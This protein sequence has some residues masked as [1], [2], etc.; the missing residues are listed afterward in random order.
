MSSKTTPKKLTMQE[1]D[2]SKFER[3]QAQL[4][5]LYTEI[6]VLAKGKPGDAL[7]KFKLG[8]INKVLVE[9]N[10]ILDDESRPFGDFTHFDEDDM[11]TNSD[12]LL[13]LSMYLNGL[14]K[15][16]ADNISADDYNRPGQWYWVTDGNMSDIRTAPPRKLKY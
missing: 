4:Q 6:G 2:I 16:R 10:T 12:V 15:L 1:S 5:S 9:A 14:E 13:I 8:I 7:N 11:P 3:L